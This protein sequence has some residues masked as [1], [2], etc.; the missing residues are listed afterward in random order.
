MSTLSKLENTFRSTPVYKES[1]LSAMY[2]SANINI[3][4]IGIS[5]IEIFIFSLLIT[6][7]FCILLIVI[8]LILGVLNKEINN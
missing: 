8:S 2:D 4:R 7:V 6:F 5:N 1:F 3:D